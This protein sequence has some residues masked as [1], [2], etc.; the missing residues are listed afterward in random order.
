MRARDRGRQHLHHL[1]RNALAARPVDWPA[2]GPVP[3][4]RIDMEG[5]SSASGGMMALTR[6][7]SGRRASTMG[8]DSSTRRPTRETMRSMICSRWRSSRNTVSV[9]CSV[10]PR[11]TNTLS[12][13]FTRMS[14]IW[15]R[16]AA[17]PAGPGRRLRRAD[18][19][20]SWPVR[21]SSAARPGCAMISPIR[22]ATACR[23]WLDSTRESFSRSSL[24]I[25]VRW[26]SAL[27]FSRLRVPRHAS[28]L[29][30]SR[31]KQ[32][33]DFLLLFRLR[34]PRRMPPWPSAGSRREICESPSA[35]GVAVPC[36]LR[37]AAVSS[38]IFHCARRVSAL[39]MCS[40]SIPSDEACN[41]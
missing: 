2:T 27:Y 29:L 5:P 19:P 12:L 14:E 7:P 8:D 15:G 3:K 40:S 4:R 21:R 20:G 6:E 32:P 11:S 33:D 26:T 41:G 24:E 1:R 39:V 25:R 30:T 17:A 36:I 34:R 10:P 22:S 13:P 9:V 37:S 23:A 18:R 38:G 35:S 16:A 28:H 31:S